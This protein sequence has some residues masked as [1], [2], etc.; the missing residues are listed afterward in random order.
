MY[1]G[2]VRTIT[3]Q[4]LDAFE[5]TGWTVAELLSRSGLDIER[6]S[7]HRKLHGEQ[8]MNVDEAQVLATV[9]GLTLVWMPD[10]KAEG[11]A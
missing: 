4:L 1:T 2:W 9:L 3:E 5:K 11:A 8:R 6:S 10:A 7:L